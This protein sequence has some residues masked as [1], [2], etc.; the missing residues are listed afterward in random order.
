MVFILNL[1]AMKQNRKSAKNTS[2]LKTYSLDFML[3]K[4]LGARGTKKR[5]RFEK[6]LAEEIQVGK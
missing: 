5:E 3:D 6:S 1:N 2:R 4:H